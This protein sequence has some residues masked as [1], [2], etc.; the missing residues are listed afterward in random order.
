MSNALIVPNVTMED[1]GTYMCTGSIEFKK[2]QTST[3]VIVY[4]EDVVTLQ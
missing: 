2:L 3:K 1:K 4:G